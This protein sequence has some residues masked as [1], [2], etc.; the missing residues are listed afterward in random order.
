MG[1]GR[2]TARGGEEGGGG[3]W[4]D[5]FEMPAARVCSDRPAQPAKCQ[6][7]L[8]PSYARRV[9]TRPTALSV[10]YTSST[11]NASLSLTTRVPTE[12]VAWDTTININVRLGLFSTPD[13]IT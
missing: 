10:Y 1:G 5:V 3:W 2:L 4:R 11:H 13:M 12:R 7:S 8:V 9:D 6:Q